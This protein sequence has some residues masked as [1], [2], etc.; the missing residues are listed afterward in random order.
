V[1]IDLRNVIPFDMVSATNAAIARRLRRVA[2]F[3]LGLAVGV[4]SSLGAARDTGLPS[5]LSDR[6]F[7]QLSTDFSEPNGYFRSD[8]LTS[9]E[10]GF[11]RVI[12]DLLTRA[13][14]GRV[15]LGV[16]PEQN[17][18]YIAALRPALAI[19]IDVRRGNLLVHLMYKALFELSKD[20][21]EFVSLLFSKPRPAGVGPHSTAADLFAAFGP[22]AGARRALDANPQ[23][24][25]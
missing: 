1:A 19:V 23:G 9:N 17:F 14:P 5:S 20:R 24:D 6:D 25:R 11:Q 13:Q 21:A 16:G 12:P 22:R 8:T 3:V 2:G 4:S 10:L 7:W 15:Y 18:T